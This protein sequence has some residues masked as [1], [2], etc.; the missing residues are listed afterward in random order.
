MRDH[1]C[2]VDVGTG[3]AR[4]GVFGASGSMIA[5]AER[6]ILMNEPLPNHAEHDSEDIWRAVCGAVRDA[7]AKS[8]VSAKQIAGIAFDATCSLVIRGEG[9]RQISVSTTGEARWDTIVWLDHRAL[10]EAESCTATGHRVLDFIG[11]VMSPEMQ[12]PKLMWLKRHCPASWNDA[13]HFFD[14][15]DFLSWKACGSMARSQ[16]TLTAK[17]TYLAHENGWQPDF[18][19]I[20]G[21]GDMISRGGLPSQATAVGTAL[22]RLS[23][24]AAEAMSLD[25]DC[26]VGTGLIDAFAGA[27]GVLGG[28]AG[29][30]IDKH[31]ALITGTSSCVMGLAQQP[32]QAPGVWGPYY[33]AALPGY[34]LAES[35]QS[36]TGA[37][38]D[39]II[40]LF[41]SDAV[42]DQAMHRH[43]GERIIA[44]RAE[45]DYDLDPAIHILPDFHGNRSPFADARAR[46]VISG[47]TLDRS[48]DGL[49]RIYWR[50]AVAIALGIRHILD[51]LNMHGYRI[52][53]LH[54]TGGHARNPLFPELYAD[55]TGCMVHQ[56][57][58]EDAMLLGT[59]MSAASAAGL[60][61]DV[62][63]AGKRMRQDS[64]IREPNAVRRTKYDTDYRIFLRMHEHRQELERFRSELDPSL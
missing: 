21:L 28:F 50:T 45:G 27:I 54:I 20:V 8:G 35:G 32:R 53:T 46:G 7:K 36:A 40:R 55:V 12:T 62:A 3:S 9:G 15:A 64:I 37:L 58:A 34:W 63:Q 24:E 59:A 56:S 48:F 47:L 57:L 52:D 16:C 2:A 17:W 39:H 41:G 60:F 51:H 44:M 29:D 25:T 31:L 14:L 4:A 1:V 43:I 10:N 13:R 22:G 6:P 30:E 33:G 18:F 11:G 42:P 38:L 49:C 19:D 23:P 61:A 26:I 5:R